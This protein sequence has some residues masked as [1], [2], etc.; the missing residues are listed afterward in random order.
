[1]SPSPDNGIGPDNP[2]A[3]GGFPSPQG[4]A[5]DPRAQRAALAVAVI[6]QNARQISM[7]FPTTAQEM[8]QVTNLM[9]SVQ[10]KIVSAAPA[11]ET[12]SPPV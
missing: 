4:P 12:T 10:Q 5:L 3:G 11:P 7:M 2:G 6:V 9:Y 1:M 8:R